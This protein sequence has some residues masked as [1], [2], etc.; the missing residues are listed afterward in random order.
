MKVW[1]NIFKRSAVSEMASSF[2]AY[3]NLKFAYIHTY[4]C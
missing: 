3:A 1:L 2:L 4:V